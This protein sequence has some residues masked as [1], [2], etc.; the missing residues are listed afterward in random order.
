MTRLVHAETNAGGSSIAMSE[1][2][3]SVRSPSGF[4]EAWRDDLWLAAGFLTC[5]VSPPPGEL[6]TRALASAARA[7]S[8]V[9]IGLGIAAGVVYFIAVSVGLPPAVA[10]ACS[11]ASLVLA[12]GALHEDGLAD[13]LDGFG[14]GADPQQ[15]LAIMRDG[16]SGP[17]GVI[18]ITFSVVI[19][20]SALASLV[21]PWSVLMALIAAGA[22]SRAAIPFV[23]RELSAARP[24]GLGASAGVP[25]RDDVVIGLVIAGGIAVLTVGLVG[26]LVALSVGAASA[27]L[28]ALMAQ[29]QIGGFTGD[30]LGAVQQSVE[31]VVLL[32]LVAVT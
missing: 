16:R 5:L 6:A 14:G 17:F 21:G 12:T 29:R 10:A 19:R 27:T 24:D 3:D 2:N 15:K 30:V 7:F 9:G 4:I 8:L 22:L 11:V 1:P 26:A 32:A 25:S 23:M 13:V 28:V 31:I 18:A 20:V